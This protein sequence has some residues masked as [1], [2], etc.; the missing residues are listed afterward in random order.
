MILIY[1]TGK[2]N[3]LKAVKW[4]L[5]SISFKLNMLYISA[6]LFLVEH[7]QK[8]IKQESIKRKSEDK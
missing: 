2:L 1:N 3:K 8:K 5:Y 4:R 7:L 6:R